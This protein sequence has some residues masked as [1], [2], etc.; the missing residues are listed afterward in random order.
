MRTSRFFLLVLLLSLLAACPK[1]GPAPVDS[2]P[3]DPAPEPTA[4][5]AAAEELDPKWPT[6]VL[7]GE[8]TSVRW[9]DG[10]TFSFKSGPHK[11]SSARLAG[12]NSLESYGPVHRWGDWTPTQLYFL[13]KSSWKLGA[14]QTWTCSSEGEKDHYGRLL[15]DCPEAALAMVS[16]GHGLVFGVDD[17]PPAALLAAQATAMKTKKGMWEKG[18]PHEVITSL[19]SADEGESKGVTYNRIV[20]TRTG[21]SREAAHKQVFAVCEEVCLDGSSC[22]IY[23][24]FAQRY[25]DKPDCLIIREKGD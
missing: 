19:H 6:V 9:S 10:D 1:A 17:A 24:P 12:Y 22:M 16:E 18:N 15:V 4:S 13:A 7:N 8:T 11:R 25:K 3:S 21:L 23:V 5:P 2:G 20:D 14:A